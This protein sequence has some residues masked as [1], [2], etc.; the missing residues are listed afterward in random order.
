MAKRTS[1]KWRT[2][3]DTEI[4]LVKGM[5]A[6][7]DF[8]RDYI[9]SFFVRPG[10]VISPAV[11]SELDRVRPDIL[12]ATREEITEFINRRLNEANVGSKGHHGFEPTSPVRVRE[13]LKLSREGQAALPGFESVFAEFKRDLPRDK[14]A[15][16][17]VAKCLAA[18]ANHE[19]GYLFFGVAN[20]GEVVGVPTA[21]IEKIWDDLS[22][23][24]TKNFTP[25]FR[26]SR[27]T[28]PMENCSIAV[29]YAYGALDKPIIATRDFTDEICEGQ[30]YFRYN[31]SNEPIRAG[32]L[33]RMLHERDRRTFAQALPLP[34]FQA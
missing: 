7:E 29:A 6:F 15:R 18:F 14:D 13:V 27:A 16:A 9:T 26:W 30:I 4:A 21:G 1:G 34:P 23:V 25:F 17:K 31:R 3:D 12:P 22:T 2:L 19:G 11:V 20:D 10:R 8:P 33:L 28:V 5:K 24:I 32:D